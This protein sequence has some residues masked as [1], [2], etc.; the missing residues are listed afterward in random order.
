MDKYVLIDGVGHHIPGMS[1][2]E[3]TMMELRAVDA[4]QLMKEGV[5]ENIDDIVGK[6]SRLEAEL[7]FED[8]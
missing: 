2:K 8:S 3:G 6:R 7:Q 4:I 1:Q 5:W